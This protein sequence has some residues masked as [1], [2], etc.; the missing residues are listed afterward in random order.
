MLCSYTWHCLVPSPDIA[1]FLHLTLCTFALHWFVSLPD[2]ALLLHLTFL[3]SFTIHCFVNSPG[4]IW[5]LHLTLPCSFTWHCLVPSPD[6]NLFHLLT[7]VCSFTLYACVVYPYLPLLFYFLYLVHLLLRLLYIQ[8][9]CTVA[10]N[11]LTC[12]SPPG[13]LLLQASHIQPGNP[14]CLL[15][16]LP[17]RVHIIKSS[18][19]C[20]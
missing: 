16:W 13:R 3:C 8:V 9:Y 14:A 17:Y 15:F 7:L 11:L 20:K 6:V 18:V 19:Q 5:F 12:Y 4:I 10:D 1:L 2:I